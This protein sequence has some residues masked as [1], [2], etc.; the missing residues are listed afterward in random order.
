MG[1]HGKKILIVGKGVS[2]TGAYKALIKNGIDC[3]LAEG[4]QAVQLLKTEDFHL[5][6]VSPAVRSDGE[7]FDIARRK[8]IDIIGEIELGYLM[9]NGKIAAVTG[10][11]G[12]TTV[13]QMLYLMLSSI[14]NTVLCGNIGKS[15]AESAS[16]GV[17]DAAVVEVSSFQLETIRRFKPDVAVI[18]NISE[19]HLDRH[20]TMERYAAVKKRI[21]QN[22]TSDDT[23]ILSQDGIPL[24]FLSDFA[25]ESRVVFTCIRGKIDGAYMDEG[26]FYYYDEFLAD[27]RQLPFTEKYNY[28]NFLLAAAAARSMGVSSNLIRRSISGFLPGAH[29]LSFIRTLNGVNFYDDSKGT[30]VAATVA[31]LKEMR[32]SVCL[33]AGGSDKNSSFDAFFS[34]VAAPAKLN[35]I[36]QT[37]RKIRDTAYIN[38]FSN[39]EI[40][41]S[42][43]DAVL[44]A[45]KSGCE[46]VLFS[47]ACASFDMFKNY[48]E[49]GDKFVEIVNEL[50]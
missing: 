43:K 23:L 8:R 14:Y 37:A 20:K 11:N 42:L 33:I 34:S 47:P 21:A 27:A 29:R 5:V 6:I 12:K 2:G 24:R 50:V 25:P 35:L 41:I 44:N 13:S 9:F 4:E 46:N 28:E 17:Y 48:A 32:G 38:G 40:F 3:V 16:E 1:I 39:V 26:K 10:T 36:G 45:Y 18:T 7:V 19:D 30:N 15:F 49:R 31:A 22:Q